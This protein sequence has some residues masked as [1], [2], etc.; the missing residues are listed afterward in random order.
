MNPSASSSFGD[1]EVERCIREGYAA[2]E[3]GHGGDQKLLRGFWPVLTYSAHHLREP[4]LHR[5]I[6][7][8]LAL[9]APYVQAAL[10]E[11]RARCPLEPG[12]AAPRSDQSDPSG[13]SETAA[14]AEPDRG[15]AADAGAAENDGEGQGDV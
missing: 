2:F 9:E 3:P 4:A 7:Q 14:A 12:G 13:Q 15:R 1:A 5:A 6:T 10:D 11:S 8:Y